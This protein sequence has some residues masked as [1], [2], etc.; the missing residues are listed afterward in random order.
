MDL[1]LP[2]AGAR[3]AVDPDQGTEPILEQEPVR[4][5][6][7]RLDQLAEQRLRLGAQILEAHRVGRDEARERAR[8][9]LGDEPHRLRTIGDRR[10]LDRVILVGVLRR[11]REH[12]VAEVAR[13]RR[14]GREPRDATR[15][16]AHEHDAEVRVQLAVDGVA[17][18]GADHVTALL[19]GETVEALL[20]GV[21]PGG[22]E[23]LT[24]PLVHLDDA[25]KR[26][27]AD[28]DE[29]LVIHDLGRGVRDARGDF[30]RN[31]QRHA[32][33]FRGVGLAS[34]KRDRVRLARHEIRD[35]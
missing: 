33:P 34:H 16:D 32:A 7:K 1:P 24:E 27:L 18:A 10:R 4:L 6:R 9:E 21:F 2:L 20:A 28:T 15:R 30:G 3:A 22:V 23:P 31:V 19:I 12:A 14:R 5:D 13:R 29:R 8:I 11:K 17:V 25:G 26:R 35:G